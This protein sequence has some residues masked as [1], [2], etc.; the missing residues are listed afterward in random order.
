[1]AGVRCHLVRRKIINKQDVQVL[2]LLVT[3][4][5]TANAETELGNAHRRVRQDLAQAVKYGVHP[6]EEVQAGAR[7]LLA[8][9][10]LINHIN[11]NHISKISRCNSRL[12]NKMELAA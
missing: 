5:V 10:N 1:M 12:T 7:C 2:P 8:H 4:A 3:A 11:N 9:L 6:A